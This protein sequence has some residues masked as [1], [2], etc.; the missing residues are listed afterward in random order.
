MTNSLKKKALVRLHGH[1]GRPAVAA[2]QKRLAGIDTEA[3]FLLAWT[4]ALETVLRENGPDLPF[5]E[6][7]RLF[8]R[9]S[10]GG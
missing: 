3:G 10:L 8:S 5:K 1:Q 4:V 9:R 2:G 7:N 6:R